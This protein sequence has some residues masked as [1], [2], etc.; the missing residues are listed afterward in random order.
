LQ[1]RD[2]CWLSRPFHLR[3][4][5]HLEHYRRGLL[6]KPETCPALGEKR[7]LVDE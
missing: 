6:V 3:K 7:I 4:P 2:V 1:T 5:V